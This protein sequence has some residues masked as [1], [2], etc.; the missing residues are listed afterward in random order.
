MA[1][2]TWTAYQWRKLHW[3]WQ[4]QHH[5]GD[6]GTTNLWKLQRDTGECIEGKLLQQ[7][8]RS[9]GLLVLVIGNDTGKRVRVPVWNDSVTSKQFSYLNLQLMFNTRSRI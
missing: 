8:Y 2:G 1:T 6:Q 5:G 4:L 7:G 9:A 3:H